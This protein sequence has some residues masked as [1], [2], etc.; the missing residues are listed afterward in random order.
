MSRVGSTASSQATH[1][2]PAPAPKSSGIVHSFSV[3]AG[4]LF[5]RNEPNGISSARRKVVDA[6]VAER[7]AQQALAQAKQKAK[8]ARSQV[9]LLEQETSE[10]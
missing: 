9:R 10:A 3:K 2:E 6:E 8:A 5:Q 1:V 4:N 7:E